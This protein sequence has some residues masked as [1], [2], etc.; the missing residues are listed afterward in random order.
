MTIYLMTASS[1]SMDQIPAETLTK[2]CLEIVEN[3][4]N[5]FVT[6][7][8]RIDR[9]R[10][11]LARDAQAMLISHLK[12]LDEIPLYEALGAVSLSP[13]YTPSTQVK[14]LRI[15][16]HNKEYGGPEIVQHFIMSNVLVHCCPFNLIDMVKHVVNCYINSLFTRYF[17]NISNHMPS[18]HCIMKCREAIDSLRN[19]LGQ[20]H[21]YIGE[22]PRKS[23]FKLIMI[24]FAVDDHSPNTEIRI[25]GKSV[26]KSEPSTT[27]KR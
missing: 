11:A 15:K 2:L 4:T 24:H 18:T 16:L 27:D 13:R 10:E 7:L 6:N 26:A 23:V 14:L 5:Y 3:V 12:Q 8:V 22:E 9:W 19:L 17:H 21:A 1:E 20:S 25:S